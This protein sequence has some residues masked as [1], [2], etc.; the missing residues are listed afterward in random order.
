MNQFNLLQQEE[1]FKK[2]FLICKNEDPSLLVSWISSTKKQ[3]CRQMTWPE[4]LEHVSE[5]F[6]TLIKIFLIILLIRIVLYLFKEILNASLI[7]LKQRHEQKEKNKG[8]Q[9]RGNDSDSIQEIDSDDTNNTNSN[10]KHRLRSRVVQSSSSKFKCT[11]RGET[12]DEIIG[13]LNA[14]LNELDEPRNSESFAL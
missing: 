11:N 13:E 14:F 6:F 9:D 1:M 12:A 7:W 5:Y 10:I 3:T 8:F 2:Y 4:I